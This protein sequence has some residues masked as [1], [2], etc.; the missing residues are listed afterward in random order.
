MQTYP[1]A[2]VLYRDADFRMLC[3]ELIW[4]LSAAGLDQGATRS[5][6][7]PHHGVRV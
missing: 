5:E 7:R 2:V 4:D 6:V 1:T 3:A